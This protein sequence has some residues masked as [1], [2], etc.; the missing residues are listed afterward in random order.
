VDLLPTVCEITGIAAPNDRK[1]DGASL[2]PVLSGGKVNRTTP[3]YWHFNQSIGGPHLA[4][5]SGDWKIL[6][7]LDKPAPAGTAL[8]ERTE[9]DF[10]SA[11]PVEF[12]LYNLRE[13]IGESR[14]VKESQAEKF[15]EMKRLLL[16]KYHEVRAE[17][18]VWPEFVPP[19]APGKKKKAN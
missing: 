4:L 13:D 3:L 9:G 19:V 5:R 14:N 15:Q 11:E 18:P 6:A 16:A 2:L 8:N 12:E 7:T 17:S 1:L 10:K